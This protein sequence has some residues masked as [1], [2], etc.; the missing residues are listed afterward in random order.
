MGSSLDEPRPSD[1]R[2]RRELGESHDHG[3]NADELRGSFG[4]WWLGLEAHEELLGLLQ[5]PK[6]AAQQARDADFRIHGRPEFH[7]SEG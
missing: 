7:S 1:R 3:A 6:R 2:P 4:I 5:F